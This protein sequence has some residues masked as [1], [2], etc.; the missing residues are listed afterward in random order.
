MKRWELGRTVARGLFCAALACASLGCEQSASQS[1][2][3]AAL[4]PSLSQYV[5]SEL[6]SDVPNRTYID[7]GGKVAL[8]GYAIEPTGVAAPGSH[9]KL[10]LYWQSLGK[11]GPGWGLFTHL[12]IPHRPHRLLDSAG[13]LRK[14]VPAAGGGEHQALGPSAWEVGKVYV[15][16]LEFDIPPDV[17][18]PELTIVA[19]VWRDALRVVKDGEPE[20]PKLALPGLRLPVLSGA[21]DDMQ[22]AIVLHI[23]TGIPAQAPPTVP[24][25]LAK[26]PTMKAAVKIQNGANGAR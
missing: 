20:D 21:V 2:A 17:R 14:S 15:D 12:V 8:V 4:D 5:L 3:E 16:P 11:L 24:S 9:V 13:P 26:A 18:V 23:E 7:F 1:D 6:P 19:G 22:R 10:T 25:A